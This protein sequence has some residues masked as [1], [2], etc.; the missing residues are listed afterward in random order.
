MAL[1]ASSLKL[2]MSQKQQNLEVGE[3]KSLEREEVLQRQIKELMSKLTNANVLSSS[4][5]VIADVICIDVD[6]INCIYEIYLSKYAFP[7][8]QHKY[9]LMLSMGTSNKIIIG[10]SDCTMKRFLS[11]FTLFSFLLLV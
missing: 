9:I 7:L 3:E 2:R 10:V 6:I 8:K 5:V 4:F 11:V 1:N